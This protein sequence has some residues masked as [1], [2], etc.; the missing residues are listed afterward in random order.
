M[1][2]VAF[3]FLLVFLLGCNK[4][5]LARNALMDAMT[6]GQWK[7]T[8]FKD[9]TTDITTLFTVYTFQFKEN[10]TVDIIHN[11]S[12]EKTGTWTADINALTITAAFPNVTD[13]ILLLNGT[14]HITNSDWTWVEAY[15]TIN[16]EQ[17]LLRMEK[18]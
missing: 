10:Y 2:Q 14:W 6:H 12:I 18:L 17:R 3:L 5:E 15:Q 16:G 9:N 13:P 4:E 1:K 11:N 7:I 8:S